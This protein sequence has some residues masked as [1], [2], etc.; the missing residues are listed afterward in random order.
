MKATL[1]KNIDLV[2][3]PIYSGVSEYYFPKNVDWAGKKIDKML[4]LIPNA[5]TTR[6]VSPIDGTTSLCTVDDTTNSIYVNLLTSND[7]E[8]MHNVHVDCLSVDNN[9]TIDINEVLNTSVC[10]FYFR[11]TPVSD[12]VILIYVFY[13]SVTVEDYTLPSKSVTVRFPLNAGQ[14]IS[15]QDLINTYIHALPAKVKSITAWHAE[16]NPAYITLRDHQL[17][18][19]FRDVHT[20]LMRPMAYIYSGTYAQVHPML[21]N[22]MDVDFDYSYVRNATT[23][24]NTQTLTFGF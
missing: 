5:T 9:H 20:N 2:Q 12:G 19:I 15:F 4:F 14:Q 3:I 13:D 8:I 23:Q 18:Y 1:Y 7:V 16:K 21:L 6:C 17:S 22:D 11:N 10:R 24:N